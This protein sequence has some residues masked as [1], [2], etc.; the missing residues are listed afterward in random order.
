MVTQTQSIAN[1]SSVTT[2]EKVEGVVLSEAA[3]AEAEEIL[4]RR[5]QVESAG[6]W[7]RLLHWLA[8]LPQELSGPPMTQ[9][10]RVKLQVSRA[11]H[12]RPGGQVMWW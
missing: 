3:L 2:P 12:E 5:Q 10:E 9:Q 11:Q 6:P 4:R 8:S 7:A 1:D